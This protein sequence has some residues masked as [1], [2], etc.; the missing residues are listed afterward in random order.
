MKKK[1]ICLLSAV[2][3]CLGTASAFAASLHDYGRS[4][5]NKLTVNSWDIAIDTSANESVALDLVGAGAQADIDYAVTYN[6]I[7]TAIRPQISIG[8]PTIAS[9]ENET[10]SALSLGETEITLA[11]GGAEK[12]I[13]VTVSAEDSYALTTG[14]QDEVTVY[15]EISDGVHMSGEPIAVPGGTPPVVDETYGP[16]TAVYFWYAQNSS[17]RLDFAYTAEELMRLYQAGFTT[18]TFY[19][20]TGNYD[21]GS[22][23]GQCPQQ[24][25][26]ASWNTRTEVQQITQ[27]D[28]WTQVRFDLS[29]FVL[30]SQNEAF[31]TLTPLEYHTQNETMATFYFS[32]ETAYV[33][34]FWFY[35]T[36]ITLTAELQVSEQTEEY[37]VPADFD[38]ADFTV[39]SQLPDGTYEQVPM[40]ADMLSDEDKAKLQTTGTHTLTVHYKNRTGTTVVRI[41]PYAEDV[42][43]TND[44][45][46]TVGAA[47]SIA[48]KNAG[49]YAVTYSTDGE[50]YTEV[51]PSF[52]SGSHTVY[53]K[54]TGD[55]ADVASGQAQVTIEYYLRRF[56]NTTGVSAK[57]DTTWVPTSGAVYSDPDY[58]NV[59][60]VTVDK[61]SWNPTVA[62]TLDL[63]KEELQALQSAGFTKITFA[64]WCSAMTEDPW[65]GVDYTL[66]TGFTSTFSVSMNNSNGWV[67]CEIALSEVIAAY[68][69]LQD[70]SFFKITGNWAASYSPFTARYTALTVE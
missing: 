7:P 69:T 26:R 70:S 21:T 55:G 3:L 62:F 15:G 38:Y 54:V 53:W 24:R 32:M 27:S 13:P 66:T 10:V 1:L 68:D 59:L 28:V 60:S 64:T 61:D 33:S 29:D 44:G 47:Y 8:D 18:M 36:G 48:V 17:F 56:D 37:A 46:N 65:W 63:T 67:P 2:V 57:G 34:G 23:T 16:Y 51:N 42:Y 4:D 5:G 49:D 14:A 43:V 12:S 41:G 45:I 50:I 19:V 22:V 25:I 40:T 39:T 35:F 11:Y 6:G 58:G 9:V 31:G 20:R 52:T 30:P